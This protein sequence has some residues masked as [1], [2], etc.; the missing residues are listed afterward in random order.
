[1]SWSIDKKYKN[2]AHNSSDSGLRVHGSSITD[3]FSISNSGGQC[4]H[5]DLEHLQMIIKDL[6][7]AGVPLRK[8]P[9]EGD[10]SSAGESN[11]NSSWLL[12][13]KVCET[14]GY[15]IV[16]TQGDKTDYRYY[17]S[18]LECFY[19]REVQE[20]FDDEECVFARRP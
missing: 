14:C 13:G 9:L 8:T 1:M 2:E 20:Y 19:H 17:C 16:V 3:E 6:E 18:N 5:I 15:P 11:A 4:I 10:H 7:D 12:N